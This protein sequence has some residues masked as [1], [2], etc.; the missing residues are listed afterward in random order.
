MLSGYPSALYDQTLSSWTRHTTSI[1]N[2]AAGGD[3]KARETEVLWC[4]F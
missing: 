1:A 3:T 2:H 4:N